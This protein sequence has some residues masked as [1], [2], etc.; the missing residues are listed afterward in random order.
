LKRGDITSKHLGI[1]EE[2][3]VP[4]RH[5]GRDK[6]GRKVLTGG[7]VEH[8]LL[9]QTALNLLKWYETI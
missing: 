9:S 1:I 7:Q 4:D 5:S 6:I 3:L 8:I 2:G